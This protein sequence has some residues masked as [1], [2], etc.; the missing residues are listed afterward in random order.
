M[1]LKDDRILYDLASTGYAK[2]ILT[3]TLF[4]HMVD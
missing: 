3:T 4:T 1:G 2:K